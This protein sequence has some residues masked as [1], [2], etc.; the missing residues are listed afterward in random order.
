MVPRD[1]WERFLEPQDSFRKRADRGTIQGKVSNVD[2]NNDIRRYLTQT[3]AHPSCPIGSS[4]TYYADSRDNKIGQ[5][6]A[7]F[8]NVR[9][10]AV[11]S[12][13]IS[14]KPGNNMTA[15]TTPEL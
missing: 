2:N 11:T 13:V 8:I 14:P 7:L 15:S 9:N 6:C 3:T 10:A 12:T 4:D 1:G 5:F